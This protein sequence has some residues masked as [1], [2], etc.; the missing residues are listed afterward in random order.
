M[1]KPEHLS[2]IMLPLHT[3]SPQNRAGY[4]FRPI[5]ALGLG[6]SSLPQLGDEY[7]KLA[8]AAPWH[9]SVGS[10]VGYEVSTFDCFILKSA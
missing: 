2:V 8:V 9:L 4:F 7:T 5:A 10:V 3:T 6:C 1:W